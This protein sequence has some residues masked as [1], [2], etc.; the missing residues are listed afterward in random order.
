M[1]FGGS[2]HHSFAGRM[3]LPV[4]ACWQAL[5]AF[6]VFSSPNFGL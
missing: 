3:C 4:Y 5:E 2:R 1:E 6:L